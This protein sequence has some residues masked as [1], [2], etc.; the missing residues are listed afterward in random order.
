MSLVRETNPVNRRSLQYRFP[1]SKVTMPQGSRRDGMRY[2]DGSFQQKSSQ[3]VNNAARNLRLGRWVVSTGVNFKGCNDNHSVERFPNGQVKSC[4]LKPFM[5]ITNKVWYKNDTPIEFYEN[6]TVKSGTL[7]NNSSELYQKIGNYYFADNTKI[8]F[9]E[10]GE[11][12]S[13]YLSDESPQL[14]K[15]YE[16]TWFHENGRVKRATLRNDTMYNNIRWSRLTSVGFDSDGSFNYARTSM[17]IEIFG[18]RFQTY[19][20]FWFNN[21]G[22]LS[23]AKPSFSVKIGGVVYEADKKIYFHEDNK[24]R[25]GMLGADQIFDGVKYG[26]GDRVYFDSN[27]RLKSV[28]LANDVVVRGVRCAAGDCINFNTDG[29]FEMVLKSVKA[30][31]TERESDGFIVIYAGT[32][33]TGIPGTL[34]NINTHVLYSSEGKPIS[35]I[36]SENVKIGGVPCKKNHVT[37]LHPNGKVK[38]ANLQASYKVGDMTFPAESSLIFDDEGRVRW[39]KLWK[40]MS[41]KGIDFP[42][43]SE[44]KLDEN[45]NL[46]S[47]KLPS[48][49]WITSTA[50]PTCPVEFLSSQRIIEGIDLPAGTLVEYDT[51]R[52]IKLATLCNSSAT[53]SS[54]T[55]PKGS[56]LSFTN[57]RVTRAKLGEQAVIDGR[58]F[59]SGSELFFTNEMKVRSAEVRALCRFGNYEFKAGT[60]IWFVNGVFRFAELKET[61]RFGSIKV[62]GNTTMK[63]D[64]FEKLESVML[65]KRA[66]IDGEWMSAKSLI[67]YQA[68]GKPRSIELGEPQSIQGIPCTGRVEYYSS[69]KLKSGSLSTAHTFKNDTKHGGYKFVMD[70]EG[71]VK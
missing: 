54:V 27:G 52:K 71:N 21:T 56:K 11:V 46:T 40:N 22:N 25:T 58:E 15:F 10:N 67:K 20:H 43:N 59:P 4:I 41:L 35:V 23:S 12:K 57:G 55:F 19:T 47:I 2:V 38:E 26:K 63:F 60:K 70:E 37:Y 8:E 69:G 30:D 13:G 36:P 7:L 51:N 9:H 50:C 5:I 18:M 3:V 33:V 66:L 34:F 42:A 31:I 24:V 61:H 48:G 45:G 44:V 32:L 6:G 17:D 68:N 39:A 64:R 16:K 53:T 29:T 1:K 28:E 65:R 62:P 49:E 14:S